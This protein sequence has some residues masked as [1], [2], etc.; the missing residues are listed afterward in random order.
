MQP[1]KS[2]S[3]L[4]PVLLS[5]LWFHNAGI[6]LVSMSKQNVA[7]EPNDCIPLCEKWFRLYQGSWEVGFF[8]SYGLNTH[9]SPFAWQGKLPLSFTNPETLFPSC[10]AA[11][12]LQLGWLN[13]I[14]ILKPTTTHL[15][16]TPLLQCM[17]QYPFTSHLS[18]F[19][20]LFFWSH[21]NCT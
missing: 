5:L 13:N 10:N 14:Y 1:W 17:L 2:T 6:C 8:F 11:L 9:F 4:R 12:A 16:M 3:F 7:M 21:L 19:L 18:W 20:I 15:L